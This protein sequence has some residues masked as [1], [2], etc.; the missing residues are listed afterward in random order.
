MTGA[1]GGL[2][3]LDLS[4]QAPGPFCSML[5][6]D[7]GADVLMVEVPRGAVARFDRMADQSR[8]EDADE[9]ERRRALNPLRRNKRSIAINLGEEAAAS[10]S[11]A[12]SPT[13][14]SC[15][16]GSAPA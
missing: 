15:S 16:T 10:S 12:L 2:R 8:R 13:R 7:L 4:R 3:V 6:G 5:L 1:L 14:T 11:T 9:A